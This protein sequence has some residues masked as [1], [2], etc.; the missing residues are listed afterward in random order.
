MPLTSAEPITYEIRSW[1]Y[2]HNRV[3]LVG[4]DWHFVTGWVNQ[5]V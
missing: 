4:R 5:F 3:A 1:I 2:Y